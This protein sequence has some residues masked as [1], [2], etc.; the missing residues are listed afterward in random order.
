MAEPYEDRILR[1]HFWTQNGNQDGSLLI[2]MNE[3]RQLNLPLNKKQTL[4]LYIGAL[5]V[6]QTILVMGM[7]LLEDN[8]LFLFPVMAFFLMAILIFKNPQMLLFLFILLLPIQYLLM[9]ILFGVFHISSSLLNLISA[10]KEVFLFLALFSALFQFLSTKSVRLKI[11]LPDI[12]MLLFLVYGLIHLILPASVFNLSSNVHLRWYGFKSDFLFVFIYFA[13]RLIPLSA[14]NL[15]WLFATLVAVG[16][17]TAFLGIL[18]VKLL[19]EDV[20]VKLGYT[21]YTQKHLGIIYKG[22]Y[23]L[24]EN[25]WAEFGERGQ[26]RRAVSVYMSSQPFA[27]SYLLII[28]FAL[29]L[30]VTKKNKRLLSVGLL[31]MLTALLL[32]IT[33]AVILTCLI[34]I[35]LVGWMLKRSWTMKIIGFYLVVI[36][37]FVAITPNLTNFITR[38][39]TFQGSSEKGHVTNWVKSLNFIQ[40]HPFLGAGLG[41]A[42]EASHRFKGDAAAGESE[43]FVYAAELGLIGVGLYLFLFLSILKTGLKTY[44]NIKDVEMKNAL[45]SILACGIGLLIISGISHTRGAIFVYYVFWWLAGYLVKVT[46]ERSLEQTGDFVEASGL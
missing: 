14:K 5:V 37:L 21:E 10:W 40:A 15:R 26:S 42:G 33:R 44:P 2:M 3:I 1:P 28:P 45:I 30:L 43:Y 22:R 46:S 13:G 34:E 12:L 20:F 16:I 31:L 41:I 23:G 32:T 11:I 24:A 17:I 39:L 29:S 7:T 38:T 35:L 36:L 9:M 6:L 8:V 4:A 25:F 19:K 27:Q 18:E